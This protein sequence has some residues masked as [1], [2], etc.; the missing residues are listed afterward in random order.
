MPS[1]IVLL[2]IFA[3]LVPAFALG[4]YEEPPYSE[5]SVSEVKKGIRGMTWVLKKQEGD[6]VA[7]GHDDLTDA[8]KGDTDVSAM[9]PI[10]AIRR[11]KLP[12]PEGLVIES[13][14]Y[15]WS[16]GTVALTRP[17]FG[18]R[19]TSLEEANRI[20]QEELGP[21]W[22]MAEFHDGWGWNFWAYGNVPAHQRFWVH[23]N[24]QKA[25]PWNSQPK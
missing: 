8:Y 13:R 19:L 1:R 9:L 18:Y 20:V 17:V 11:E 14:Y 23:I 4:Q 3:L 24:D 12:K 7:V 16:G 21:K 5:T 25:N 10:L 6:L 22:C 2:L 15:E